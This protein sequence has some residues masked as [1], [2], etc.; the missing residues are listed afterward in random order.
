MNAILPEILAP[1]GSLEKLK[2]A[3]LYGANAVY[4]GGQKFGLRTAAENFTLDELREGV[5]FAHARNAKVYVVL[6]S[7][8]HDKDLAELPDFVK[9]LEEIGSDAVIVSDLGVVRTV[10]A[11]SKI[12]I[13]VST[14]ASTL[15]VEAAKFWK[16]VGATRIVLGREVSITDAGRIK[17]EAQIEIEM[18]IHGSMCMSYSGNCV[19]SNFTQ[20]RDSNRGGCAHSCRVEYTLEDL[21]TKEKK[22]SFFM[23]SKDLQGL[24]LLKTFIDE[25]IDSL[26][27][28]GRMKSHLYAGTMSKVY[29]EALRYYE[30]H[31]DFLSDDLIRW[32]QELSKVSHRAYTEA[33][34]VEPAG[35]DSIFNERENNSALEWKMVGTV[36][37]ATPE[38]GI[39]IEVK[40]AFNQGDTLEVIPFLGE[41]I[42]VVASEIM[43]LIRRPVTR[44][45]PTTLVRLPF[46]PGVGASQLIRQKIL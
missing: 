22:T 40:N 44:T 14:Q 23:S 27:I 30:T 39:V 24:R 35:D 33:S 6:N 41:P 46:I 10:R 29:S 8:L 43:D 13:H 19:I 38:S 26:K 18:F 1:A 42:S 20:G 7:F 2:V 11:H 3:I 32:E 15:N 5:S 37:K 36:L 17:R 16:S 45:K 21:N 12:P 4:A 9:F 34:L 25:G 31:G 28:E